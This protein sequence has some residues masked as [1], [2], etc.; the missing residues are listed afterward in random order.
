MKKTLIRLL[1]RE[2][3]G[4]VLILA[5]IL[6]AVGSLIIVP[7]VVFMGTGL[8]AAQIVE[9]KANELYAADAGIEDATQKIMNDVFGSLDIDETSTPYTL[10]EQIN[11]LSVTYTV[12]K[13]SLIAG[14]IGE[15]EY[16][17]GQ[18]HEDW[19][20]LSSPAEAERT[21]E[22]VT[23]TCG[24]S[25]LYEGN[26]KRKVETLGAF[27]SPW[28]G[29]ETLI[30]GPNNIGY[31]PVMT[32]AFL[33]VGSPE[34]EVGAGSFAFIWRWENNK[35]PEFDK[36]NQDGAIIFDFTVWNPNWEIGLY[37]IWATF[38]EQ[39]ISYVTNAPGMYNWL[40]E[41]TAGDTTVT[42]YIIGGAGQASILSFE[43]N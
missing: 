6:L 10:T 7:L 20:S 38:K 34:L 29:S 21:D 13:I 41:A 9:E 27:F 17:E 3:Q 12:T 8:L 28:P 11:G 4:Q 22:Y 40:V 2:E 18:P 24:V 31:T 15:G 19:V 33:E 5:L 39:D 1:K 42:S 35:G 16:K 30:D 14:F 43:I 23:Y 36:D 26:G 32:D 37:F 25:F